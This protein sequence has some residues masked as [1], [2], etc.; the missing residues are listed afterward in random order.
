MSSIIPTGFSNWDA[1]FV[2]LIS[3]SS[4]ISNMQFVV[5][6]EYGLTLS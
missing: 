5:V 4:S 2:N 3:N 6:A 1:E